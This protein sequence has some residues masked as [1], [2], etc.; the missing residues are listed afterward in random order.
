MFAA[1]GL[2][3]PAR[4]KAL[5][6]THPERRPLSLVQ[7]TWSDKAA[8]RRW[9]APAPK[10]KTTPQMGCLDPFFCSCPGAKRFASFAVTVFANTG[11]RVIREPVGIVMDQLARH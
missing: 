4:K 6:N 7:F 9:P 3:A 1:K 2:G 10:T 11:P 5:A 8:C